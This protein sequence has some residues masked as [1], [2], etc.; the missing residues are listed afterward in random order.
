[1]DRPLYSL[2]LFAGAGGGILADRLSGI[3]PVCAVELEPFPRRIL[4]LRWPGMAVW[5]DVRTFRADNPECAAAFA[6]LREHRG[7]LLVAGGF[8]CQ[9]IS[10]AGKGAG[11]EGGERSG[12]WREFARILREVGPRFVFVENSPMLVSRG[13]GIVLGDLAR[14]GMM[15]SGTCWPLAT[16][17]RDTSESAS[18]SPDAWPTV[19]VCGNNN[20][21]GASPKSGD[22]L[23]T[24]VRERE[25][26]WPTPNARDWKDTGATQGNR[27][28]P[29]LGTVVHTHTHTA[30]RVPEVPDA[31]MPRRESGND[32]SARLGQQGRESAEKPQRLRAYPTPRVHDATHDGPSELD[33]HA[34]NLATLVRLNG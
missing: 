29:N 20:R 15:L 30:T 17:A 3:E 21:K 16:L 7:Q 32:R 22:G 2:H 27:H 24:R 11:V 23:M 9:D 34:P 13:L 26:S 31:P 4:A 12:L 5:D 18:G 14:S 25:S 6:W 10:S 28:S 19:T 1:M 33:R 8:P